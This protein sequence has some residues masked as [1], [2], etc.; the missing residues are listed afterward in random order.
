MAHIKMGVCT[1]TFGDQPLRLSAERVA[2]LGFGD[3]ELLGDLNRYSAAEAG[4]V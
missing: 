1:W 2:A 3:V 4:K